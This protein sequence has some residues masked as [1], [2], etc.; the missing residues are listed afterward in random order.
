MRLACDSCGEV[1][2]LRLARTGSADAALVTCVRCGAQVELPI[3]RDAS[4]ARPLPAPPVTAPG[5]EADRCPKCHAALAEHVACPGCGLARSRMAGFS[6]SRAAE[7]PE[8][9]RAAWQT[10]L[11]GWDEQPRHDAFV[12]AVAGAGA[13][14]WAAGQYQDERRRRPGDPVA[15]RQLERVRRT[16]EAAMLASAAVRQDQKAPYRG[17]TAILVMMVVVLVAGALYATFM[18]D[19]RTPGPTT[20]VVPVHRGARSP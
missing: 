13:F 6:A 8:E 20:P 19:T 18:R 11:D 12:Q 2:E 1:G 5:G 3:S 7:V 4:A 15:T 14:A 16:A 10:I 17:A 9:V